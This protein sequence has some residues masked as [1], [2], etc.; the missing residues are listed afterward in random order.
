VRKRGTARGKAVHDRRRQ[1]LGLLKVAARQDLGPGD[2]TSLALVPARRKVRGRYVAREPGVVAGLALLPDVFRAVGGGVEARPLLG[3]GTRIR[4][5]QLLAEVRGPARAVLAG[6]RL[7]LNILCRLSGIATLTAKYVRRVAGTGA[8][9]YDT[10]KTTPGLTMIEKYAVHVGGGTNHRLGLW[11]GV[12]IKD[13]H[14]AL[15]GMKVGTAV[16]RARRLAAG[17]VEVEVT[18]LKQLAEAIRAGAD[19]VMLDNFRAGRV[20][21]AVK[22]ARKLAAERGRPVKVEVSGGVR[23]ANVRR[24]AEAGV[25][26]I[27]VGELTHSPRALDISLEFDPARPA[28]RSGRK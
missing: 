6:E 18:D 13:N 22:R 7:S 28:S 23:L 4:R 11:D 24:L 15:L 26:R 14:L 19:I 12:L 10:R 1:L 27:S 3:E 2:V 16:R 21:G 20:A 5:G 9:I 8:R 25:D 17:L